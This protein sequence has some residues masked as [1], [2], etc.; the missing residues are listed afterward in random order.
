MTIHEYR[1]ISIPIPIRLLSDPM[2][3]RIPARRLRRAEMTRQ[4]FFEAKNAEIFCTD[5]SSIGLC[6]LLSLTDHDIEILSLY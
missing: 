5:D 3:P 1:L 2:I 6:C 4:R